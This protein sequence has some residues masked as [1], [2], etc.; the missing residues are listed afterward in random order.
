M[1]GMRERGKDARKFES[2]DKWVQ[3]SLAESQFKKRSRIREI[4]I[5]LM[6]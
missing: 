3:L 5:C 1:T 4:R 6:C 2:W